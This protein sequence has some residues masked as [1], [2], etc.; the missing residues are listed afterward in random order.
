VIFQRSVDSNLDVTEELIGLANLEGRTRAIDIL[1]ADKIGARS[2]EINWSNLVSVCTDRAPS[3]IGR[4][5]GFCS[6][7]EHA[8]P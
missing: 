2:F 8:V 6:Q 3:M 1:Q 5:N 4:V 7:L